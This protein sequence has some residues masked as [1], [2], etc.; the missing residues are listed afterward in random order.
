MLRVS[1]AS[2][3]TAVETGQLVSQHRNA[4]RSEM[5][6]TTKTQA[7]CSLRDNV[8]QERSCQELCS[9]AVKSQPLPGTFSNAV[10]SISSC[11]RSPAAPGQSC[12]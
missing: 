12:P 8:S 3:C 10:C 4:P 6:E 2:E 1:R 9:R 11:T 7:V 5:L